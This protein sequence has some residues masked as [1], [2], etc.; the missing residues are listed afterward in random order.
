[1][2]DM[3]FSLLHE[4]DVLIIVNKP[5]GFHTAPLGAGESDT[6]LTLILEAFPEISSVPGIK[7]SEPGLLHRLDR[8]TSGVV[9]IAR[10]PAAFAALRLQF[11]SGDVRKEYY[12]ACACSANG[13]FPKSI[14]IQSMFAPAGPGRRMVRVVMPGERNRRL[15][16]KAARYTYL[17]EARLEKLHAGRALL[18][19]VI[20][21]GFRHQVRAHLAFA[22]FPIFGDPL[23]GVPAPP[24]APQRMYLHASG[25]ELTHPITGKQLRIVSPLPDEFLAIL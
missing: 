18:A 19:M 12:A 16:R 1:M 9:V 21:K 22:G 23:Y 20:R 17:T 4:D 2:E 6:L 14:S 15:L 24:E 13:G 5:A 10:T 7:P 11:A 8:D 3:S 25:I